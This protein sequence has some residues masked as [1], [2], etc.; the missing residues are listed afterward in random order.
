MKELVEKL[1][2]DE[3]KKRVEKKKMESKLDK[4]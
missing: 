1:K 3:I 2:A 4:L